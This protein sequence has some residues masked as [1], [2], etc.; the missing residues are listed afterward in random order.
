MFQYRRAAA[1]TSMKFTD[2]KKK[3]N[4]TKNPKTYTHTHTHKKQQQQKKP[5]KAVA[6]CQNSH[7]FHAHEKSLCFVNFYQICQ[8]EY[9][10][11]TGIGSILK[12]HQF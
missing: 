6:N 7:S 11:T 3:T 5:S 9:F 2:L 1:E 8:L 12:S 10:K 4:Q